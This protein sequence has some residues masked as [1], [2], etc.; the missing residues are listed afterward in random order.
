MSLVSTWLH[1]L[2]KKCNHL[3]AAESIF[4]QHFLSMTSRFFI[5]AFLVFLFATTETLCEDINDEY[6]NNLVYEDF[7]LFDFVLENYVSISYDLLSGQGDFL[8]VLYR[9]APDRAEA[10][11][12]LLLNNL[13]K[14][15]QTIPEFTRSVV[16]VLK[17][18]AS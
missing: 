13:L 14:T 7:I 3:S 18:P 1:L 16:Q 2:K 11:L 9:Q 17:T 15:A 6:H 4:P 10:E 8:D 5:P 12:Y